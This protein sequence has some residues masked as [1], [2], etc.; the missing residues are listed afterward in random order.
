MDKVG[1]GPPHF[2]GKSFAYWMVRMSAYL[3]ALSPEAWFATSVGYPRALMEGAQKWNALARSKLFEAISEDVFARVHA[4]ERAYDIWQELINIHEG[5]SKIRE[6][7][8]HVLRAKYDTFKMMP[9]EYCNDM[10]SR[11]NVLVK[12]INALEI[13]RINN[14][15]LN[16]KILMLLP[17]PK[18]NIINAMLQKENLDTLEVS[19]LVGGD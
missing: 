18:Y 14:G 2:N 19:E 3:D 4:L 1:G 8:Y 12:E 5:S 15:N 11:L 7:K 9:N 13:C 16:R 10:Y 6:Q 17:K